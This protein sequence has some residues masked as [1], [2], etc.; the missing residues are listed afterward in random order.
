MLKQS[1]IALLVFFTFSN[2]KAQ[3]KSEMF[4][5]AVDYSN[6]KVTFAYLNQF[7]ASLPPDK[8]ETKSFDKIKSEFG[9]CK[10]GSAITYFNL[11]ELLNNNNFKYSNQKFSAVI[12]GIKNS[13]N[14]AYSKDEAINKILDGIYSNAELK[15]ARLKNSDIDKLKE[16]LQSEISNYFGDSFGSAQT[17]IPK[18]K[19]GGKEGIDI[20]IESEIS[21]LD[22]KIDDVTPGIFSPNWLSIIIS[23]L[24]IICLL[25]LLIKIS[26]LKERV[27]RYRETSTLNSTSNSNWNQEQNRGFNSRELSEYKK[28]IESQMVGALKAISTLQLEVGNLENKLSQ[29]QE[30]TSYSNQPP[31]QSDKPQKI[32]F[33]YASIPEKDGSFNESAITTSI[34]PTASFYKFTI[35][36]SHTATFEFIN[37]ERAVKDA[38]SSPELILY[39][40]CKI[41]SSLNQGAKKIKTT[42][43]GTLVKR[44]DKWELGT[45]AEIE[46][47]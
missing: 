10:I 7:T 8:L 20:N 19:T 32:D 13:F 43:P 6:C 18:I 24:L 9:D 23:I 12:D 22:K 42:T 30:N 25:F 35:K 2:V 4:S 1:L 46:Y 41:K 16:Q 45:K 11:S 26:D 39:P 15:N 3:D 47:E 33:F 37:D 44:G 40:V 14:E 36:D 5:K 38:T 34:N 17:V 28:S 31:I 27:D 29:R 21:R